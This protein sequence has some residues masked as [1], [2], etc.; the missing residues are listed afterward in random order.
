CGCSLAVPRFFLHKY[1]KL[2]AEV[3]F[4]RMASASAVR[5][6]PKSLT[7]PFESNKKLSVTVQLTNGYPR[8]VLIL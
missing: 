3:V 1:H 4:V 2:T 5:I 6:E 8:E 7:F